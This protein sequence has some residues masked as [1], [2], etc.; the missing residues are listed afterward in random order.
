MASKANGE[1]NLA[2]SW[3]PCPAGELERLSQRLRKR[4]QRRTF[5]R[6][7][8]ASVAVAATG[9]GLVVWL[10]PREPREFNFAGLTCT[11]VQ[12]AAMAYAQN[13]L[14]ADMRDR[15]REHVAQCPRCRPLFE[16]MGM[17]M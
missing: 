12:N 9:G 4:R 11:Q 10:R 3:V 16:R 8:A 15:V 5:L 14:D 17:R 13:E 7:A 2:S 6:V 1:Q